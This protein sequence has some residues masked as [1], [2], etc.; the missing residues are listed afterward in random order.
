MYLW[1]VLLV[2]ELEDGELISHSH[3]KKRYSLYILSAKQI[4]DF[5]GGGRGWQGSKDGKLL[6]TWIIF[7]LSSDSTS[8]L[9][10][11][12]P[13]SRNWCRNE[14]GELSFGILRSQSHSSDEQQTM[15]PFRGEKLVK[16]K[17]AGSVLNRVKYSFKSFLYIKCLA[18][19]LWLYCS[20]SLKTNKKI[21]ECEP[22]QKS[23]PFSHSQ[24]FEQG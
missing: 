14:L 3:T 23:V 12:W 18:F 4:F 20:N 17:P 1:S 19:T 15:W 5:R 8:Q 9:K 13:F 11:K 21:S 2:S 24:L 10:Q 6:Y 16:G 22:I 7:H